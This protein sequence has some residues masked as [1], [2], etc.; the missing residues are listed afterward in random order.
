[1]E[2]Q[3]FWLLIGISIAV[4]IIILGLYLIP[5]IKQIAK[6]LKS[7]GDL[8]NTIENGLRPIMNE[9]T[10]TV[11]RINNVIKEIETS[12]GHIREFSGTI[13]EMGEHIHRLNA[14][15]KDLAE[16][17]AM[18]TSKFGVGIKTALGVVAKSVSKKGEKSE[19]K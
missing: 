3:W 10:V 1:M 19:Q 7:G 11:E 16:A 18:K 8:L 4:A 17:L 12:M 13:A 6:L 2:Q 5:V 9:L 14:Q 15:L